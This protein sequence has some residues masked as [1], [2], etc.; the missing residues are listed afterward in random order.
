V[1]N[2]N[3]KKEYYLTDMVNIAIAQNKKI[4]TM[5]VPPVEAMGANTP[6]EIA[7]VSKYL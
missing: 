5:P 7:I 1:K 3:A 2:D 6:Q 4:V